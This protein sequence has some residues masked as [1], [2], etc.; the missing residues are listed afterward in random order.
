MPEQYELTG[1]IMSLSA[2]WRARASGPAAP[3]LEQALI[4][5]LMFMMVTVFVSLF[6]PRRDSVVVVAGMWSWLALSVGILAAV[7][8]WPIASTGRRVLGLLADVGLATFCLFYIEAAGA[9]LVGFYLFVIFGYGFRY[10]RV[11]LYGAQALCL[12][13]FLLA[14]VSVPWWQEQESAVAMGWVMAIMVIPMYVGVL[15]ERLKRALRNAEQALGEC[16]EQQ[17]RRA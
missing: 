12:F 14:V 10:G 17:G 8:A 1:G 5:T 4:R 2:A 6:T 7:W 3:E 11:Y 15:A 16:R 9:T 13:G